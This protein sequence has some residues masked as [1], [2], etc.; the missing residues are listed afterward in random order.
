MNV[1]KSDFVYRDG[2]PLSA[3][4]TEGFTIETYARQLIDLQGASGAVILGYDRSLL[5]EI[6]TEIPIIAK[7][8]TFESESRLK[9]ANRLSE[10]FTSATNRKG[11]I[12]FELGGAQAIELA[13][14]AAVSKHR[15]IRILVLEGSYHG[16]SLFCSNLSASRRYPLGI[17]SSVQIVRLPNPC[18]LSEIA[19]LPLEE[20]SRICTERAKALFSDE[21][22]GVAADDFCT[23][24]LLY[25]PIQNVSGMLDLP[26]EY[27]KVLEALV[28]EAGGTVIADEIFTGMHRFGSFV[29]HPEKGLSP[30][31]VVISK[32][33]TNGIVPLSA[34][35][36]ADDSIIE[37]SFQ[38]G[39]HSCTYLNNEVAFF[40]ADRVLDE[41]ETKVLAHPRETGEY[42]EKMLREQ[43]YFEGSS[44]YS[45]GHVA[46]L[47]CP[48]AEQ[49]KRLSRALLSDDD[50][51]I[52]V[53]H[54]TTGLA[55]KSLIFHPP[56]L[57]PLELLDTAAEIIAQK[58]EKL[59]NV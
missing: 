1:L 40:I 11:K 5:S 17:E 32:G 10:A 30:S 39:T 7:P 21:R 28:F 15:R 33:L 22:F 57:I 49:A 8:Q 47:T 27:L 55:K 20:A 52:G 18:L 44:F 16:R 58:Y 45:R 50:S 3:V 9:L 46:K 2:E 31:I 59:L 23:P 25:E 35:W 14:K 37:D 48:T 51:K 6:A 43:S 53:L 29:V 56:Y 26:T 13:I 42:L 4:K 34:I 38:A 19:N 12:A 41:L 36:V 24:V 54:A